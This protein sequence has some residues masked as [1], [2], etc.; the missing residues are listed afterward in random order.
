MTTIQATPAMPK[1]TESPPAS[2]ATRLL[3]GKTKPFALKAIA[4]TMALT[5]A[6]A[7][8]NHIE[9][10]SAQIEQSRIN[11]QSQPTTII[12]NTPSAEHK[13]AAPNM[14]AATLD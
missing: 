12:R 9:E 10:T 2:K 6:F 4:C 14:P 7:M 1:Q 3:N 8:R 13:E 5:A 11:M